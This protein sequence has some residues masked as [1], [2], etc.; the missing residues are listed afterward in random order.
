[1]WD[2]PFTEIRN[3]VYKFSLSPSPFLYDV[4]SA[5]FEMKIRKL[6]FKINNAGLEPNYFKVS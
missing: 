4:K 1:M 6:Q 2:L 3:T 5:M